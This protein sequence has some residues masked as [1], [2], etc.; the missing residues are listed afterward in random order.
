MSEYSNPLRVR[1]PSLPA[2]P[3][4][5]SS[6]SSPGRRN[7]IRTLAYESKSKPPIAIDKGMLNVKALR[8]SSTKDEEYITVSISK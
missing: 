3:T 1:M 5:N 7:K 2:M 6:T 4:D 8:P